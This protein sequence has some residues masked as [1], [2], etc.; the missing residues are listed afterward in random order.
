NPDPSGNPYLQYAVMLAS[1]LKGIEDE[2]EPPSSV[3]RDIYKLT[4]AQRK[5]YEIKPLPENL[6]EALDELEGSE[7]VKETLG[8]HIM[9]HFLYIKRQEWDDYRQQ[10]TEWEVDKFL[11]T[12]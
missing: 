4:E 6:A 12:L 5:Q 3:E 11:S 9:E 8:P 10:V 2:I 1:G 7:L